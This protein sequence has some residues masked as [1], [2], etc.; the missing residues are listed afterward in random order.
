MKKLLILFLFI[1]HFSL[2]GQLGFCEGSKGDPIFFEDFGSGQGY[3]PQLPAGTTNYNYTSGAPSDG[4]YT[5]SYQNNFYDWHNNNDHT[6]NDTYGKSLIINAD[7][8]PGEFYQRTITGLCE[9][10]SYEFTS[11]L[12]NLLPSST[13]CANGGIPIN[14]KFEIVNPADNS[15]LASGDT[16]NITSTGTAQWQQYGLT[17]TT[18]AGQTNV[19]LKMRNNGVGGCGNDLA[20]DDI[21]FRSC[22]DLT[23]IKSDI[24]ENNHYIIC[25]DQFPINFLL[26]AEPDFSIYKTH[27]FQWQ[28]SMDS[29]NWTDINGATNNTYTTPNIST[30]TYYRVKVAEDVI[31]LQNPLCISI[32]SPYSIEVA[33]IPAPPIKINDVIAC[34]NEVIPALN[35][36]VPLNHTANWYSTATGGTPIAENSTS[37]TTSTTG[38]YYAE[39]QVINASCYSLTRTPVTI[40]I[41]EAPVVTDETLQ[42]CKDKSLVIDAGILN[43][44]YLWSTGETTKEIIVTKPDTYSVVITNLDGCSNTKTIETSIYKDPIIKKISSNRDQIILELEESSSNYEYSINGYDYQ[45]SQ[46]FERARGGL[47]TV[48]AKNKFNCEPIQE[49]FIHLE[50]PNF[51][52]PNGDGTNDIFQFFGIENYPSAT[53]K[54][55]DRY[56][57]L[58]KMGISADFFWDG[59]LNGFSLPATD[60]W[61]EIFID[62]DNI[63]KGHFSLKR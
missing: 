18:L 7:Y 19:I 21:M 28:T 42:F 48:Y 26:I 41:N 27:V 9:N 30:N 3:G 34:S 56:G 22:G 53:V 29:S 40:T 10:T 8:N 38:T 1:V 39:T 15:I 24:S 55:F 17:F 49:E 13:A 51:F 33:Y 60:Y 35:V 20:I 50:I 43:A 63:I 52:T 14:V 25:E 36:S 46:L 37:Y 16:G 62:Q 11:W 32:S 47:Y 5:I 58:L 12:I 59:K 44:T 23:T 4:G 31:N 57:A 54:I 2:Y 61:Y 6:P 45:D